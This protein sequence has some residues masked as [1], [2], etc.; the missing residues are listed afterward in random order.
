MG[1]PTRRA[2]GAV[3]FSL[4][5]YSQEADV[6][7]LLKHLPGIIARLRQISPLTPEHPDNESYQ[8]DSSHPHRHE[9]SQDE[10]ETDDK[11]RMV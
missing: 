5:V 9:T 11:T 10:S 8:A 2:R 1:V 4:G 6:D 3:R 7:W